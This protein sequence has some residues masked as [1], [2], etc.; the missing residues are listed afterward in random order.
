MNPHLLKTVLSVGLSIGLA[1]LVP[2]VFAASE[3]VRL[4]KSGELFPDRKGNRWKYRGEVVRTPLQQ[5]STTKFENVSTV[6]GTTIIQGVEVTVFH[7]TNP[8]NHGPSDSYYRRDAAG[9]VYYGSSPGTALEKQVV[10]YQVVR[11]PLTFPSSFEQFDRK[12]LDFGRDLDGDGANEQ[13]DLAATVSL[14]GLERVSVP[15]GTYEALRVEARMTIRFHLTKTQQAVLGHDTMTA[16]FARGIGLV[17]Y[18]E[19]Q[20]LPDVRTGQ[21][22]VTVIT[23]ELEEVEIETLSASVGGSEPS[24]ERVL[25]DHS[26]DHKLGQVV[27]AAGF[28]SD[29]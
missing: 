18:T 10:P 17:K 15:A 1:V 13:T 21:D 9:I 23:E 3:P 8:G 2:P 29:P 28:C 20:Q 25:A 4:E 22:Q 7:D 19:R 11:F 12:G 6:T 5:V 27:V 26:S 16:W 14:I 24:A